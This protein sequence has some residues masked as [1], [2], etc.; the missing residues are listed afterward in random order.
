LG[1]YHIDVPDKEKTQWL[2]FRNCGVVNV[3][4][5]STNLS[6]LEKSLSAVFCK[7]KSWPWQMRELDEKNFLVRFPH[8]RMSLNSSNS[9][10]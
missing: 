3:K 1:F 8:G 9:C 5:G 7:N 4:K 6:D 2:N 10:F